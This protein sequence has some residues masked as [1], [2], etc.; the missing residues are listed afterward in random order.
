MAEAVA[1]DLEAV[2]WEIQCPRFRRI[3]DKGTFE[4]EVIDDLM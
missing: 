4:D 3:L 1:L 2:V